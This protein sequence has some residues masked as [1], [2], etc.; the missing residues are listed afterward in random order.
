MQDRQIR[1]TDATQ[2]R[3]GEADGTPY[4]EGYFVVY[5]SDYVLW[6][7]ATESIARGA[8]DGQLDGD[9]RALINHDTTLVTGRTKSGTLRLEDRQDG[10]WGH[11]DINPRDV[12]AMNVHARVMRGDVDQASFGF[13]II[14][15]EKTENLDGTVHWTIK[16]VKLYEV[17]ICTF[18]A[19]QATSLSAR[20]AERAQMEVK[21]SI[22]HL[23]AELKARIKKCSNN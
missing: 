7:G 15:E 9:I 10:L 2:F 14:D 1:F 3:A 4:I 20:A 16:A 5:D 19:Y 6:P 17:S 21:R 8:F 13:D 18:P 12:D 22:D 11:I 23:K